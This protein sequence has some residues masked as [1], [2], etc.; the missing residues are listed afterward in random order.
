MRSILIVRTLAMAAALAL[1][2]P[3]PAAAAAPPEAAAQPTTE[4]GHL[5]RVAAFER[6]GPPTDPAYLDAL[7]GLSLF[8]F[9]QG[10]HADALPVL[11][12][13]LAASERIHGA[14]HALTREIR[15]TLLL[16]ENFINR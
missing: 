16:L 3:L 8:Y 2:P 1:L 14:E 12:R 15:A 10:R 6:A 9:N 4:A 11:R 5:E 13:A 7:G